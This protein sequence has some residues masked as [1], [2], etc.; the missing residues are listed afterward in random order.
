[1]RDLHHRQQPAPSLTRWDSSG[2]RA[3]LR[4]CA[5]SPTA[6]PPELQPPA[7][8]RGRIRYP[9]FGQDEGDGPASRKGIVQGCI[10]VVH[11]QRLHQANVG[12]VLRAHV[13]ERFPHVLVEVKDIAMRL[14]GYLLRRLGGLF[15]SGRGRR[16]SF[17]L[18]SVDYLLQPRHEPAFRPFSLGLLFELFL[19]LH[20]SALRGLCGAGRR[21]SS[22]AWR[23]ASSALKSF[24]VL[25]SW[26]TEHLCVPG[27]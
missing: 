8:A 3:R 19:E 15:W 9:P 1:M 2:L 11:P 27:A 22:S 12:G 16:A 7:R 17:G 21:R 4:P 23:P 20:Q 24:S 14:L 26:H 18:L 6:A 13:G 5:S 25:N 10:L